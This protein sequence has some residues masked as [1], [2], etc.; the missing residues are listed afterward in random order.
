VARRSSEPT[1]AALRSR[2]FTVPTD[3]PEADGTFAWSKTT[4]VLVEVAAAG[5]G[6]I[7]YSYGDASLVALIDGM[8]REVVV[9]R[10]ALDLPAVW[11]AMRHAVRNQGQVGPSAMAIGAV[12]AALWDLKGRLLGLPVCRLIGRARDAVPVYGSGGFTSY[13]DQQ[14]DAQLGGWAADG[15]SWVKMKVGSDP[16]A[17]P[18]RVR[19]ARRAIGDAGLF[20]DANGAY[21]RKQAL[22][23]A[24]DFAACGVSWFE[25]PVSSNDLEGLRLL[26]ARAPAG[27]DVAAGEY[28]PA[29]AGRAADGSGAGAAIAGLAF[30]GIGVAWALPWALGAAR[31][32]RPGRAGAVASGS[33]PTAL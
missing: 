5:V 18:A 12:D 28:V 20:V 32:R 8:L 26:R 23:L 4:L 11:Q 30:L 33:P 25:E 1:I 19:R 15:L 14:L 9:G 24:D 31:R 2:A 29:P 22:A 7:G 3:A 10:S 13:S 27:M 6:G 16:A 21:T 17:D